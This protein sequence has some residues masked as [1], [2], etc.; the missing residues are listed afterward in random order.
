[1]E[2]TKNNLNSTNEHDRLN[3]LIKMNKKLK[4][5]LKNKNNIIQRYKSALQLRN[6]PTLNSFTN[7]LYDIKE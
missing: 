3:Q 4:R 5:Q 1:M 7:L 2:I 6:V